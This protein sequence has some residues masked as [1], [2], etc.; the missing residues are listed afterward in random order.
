MTT[1]RDFIDTIENADAK[2]LAIGDTSGALLLHLLV[3]MF[4]ADEELHEKEVAVLKRLVGADDDGE[5]Q[6][7]VNELNALDMNWAKL[8]ETFP[9]EK[10][11]LDIITLAEHGFW[12][13]NQMKFSEMDVLD[14]L[15]EV[16]E[17][18]DR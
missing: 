8:A 16:L 18:K 14:K 6:K 7:H 1:P 12:A 3:H 17:I 10:D 5:L 4:F 13:D 11:R 2:P 9:E 15:A